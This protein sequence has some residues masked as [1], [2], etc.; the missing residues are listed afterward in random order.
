MKKIYF[1]KKKEKSLNI[2]SNQNATKKMMQDMKHAEI[3]HGENQ[4]V[5]FRKDGIMTIYI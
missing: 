1:V 5:Y 3:L 2:R 4:T